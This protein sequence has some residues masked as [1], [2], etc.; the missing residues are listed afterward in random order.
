M[1]IWKDIEGYVGIYQVSNLGRVKS[2]SKSY[3]SG[4]KHS[5][6]KSFQEMILKDIYNKDS[7]HQVC[8]YNQGI[9]EKRYV[10]RLVAEAFLVNPDNKPEVNHKD[11]NKSNNN[12]IN[13]EWSTRLENQKHA[14]K[15][16]LVAKGEKV[17]GSF[18]KKEDVLSIRKLYQE[19]MSQTDISNIFKCS[20]TNI[21][22][23][24]NNKG[25]K[26]L[27]PT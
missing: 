5:V 4:K 9:C 26:H 10:H 8:L 22:K 24:V 27:L 15:K 16:G 17:H 6:F 7:Y 13:L 19:G 2:L 12:V 1:H 20:R 14:S 23:I 25:W 11:G 3:F 21:T 18:L